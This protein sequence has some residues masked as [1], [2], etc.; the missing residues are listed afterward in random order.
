MALDSRLATAVASLSASTCAVTGS[1]ST[2]TRRLCAC[3]CRRWASTCA[4]S[5]WRRSVLA[6]L[7][8]RAS[9]AAALKRSKASI[10]FCST[11]VFWCRMPVT[12]RWLSVNGP[13]TSSCSRATPSRMA[14][15]GVLSSWEMWRRK[16]ALSASSSVSR[17]RSHSRRWPTRRTSAGPRIWIGS[18]SR[19]SPRPTMARSSRLKGRPSHTPKATAISSASATAP[20]TS[21]MARPR[22]AS[23]CACRAWLRS[24]MARCTPW[25]I[26]PLRA[27]RVRNSCA[28]ARSR[29][30]AVSD[31]PSSRVLMW[32]SCRRQLVASVGVMSSGSRMCSTRRASVAVSS[33]RLRSRLSFSTSDWR[34]ARSRSELRSASICAAALSCSARCA[35]PL[36]C[37]I[38]WSKV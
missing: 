28:T 25:A 36:L 34:A 32:V 4:S 3:H 26:S 12:S 14:A 21:R 9:N 33:K 5:S 15:S 2:R 10:W 31:G 11:T 18:C 1:P 22:L 7:S 29:S 30:R 16:R 8:W 38:S 24:V 27:S 13:A 37:A 23:S 20:T 6:R 35:K 19:F 17:R